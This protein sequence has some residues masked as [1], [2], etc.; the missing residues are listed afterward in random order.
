MFMNYGS[1]Y[2]YETLDAF[3]AAQLR[4]TFSW[5]VAPRHWAIGT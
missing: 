3:P 2:N 1:K 4:V 5:N